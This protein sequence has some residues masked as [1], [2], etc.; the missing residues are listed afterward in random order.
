MNTSLSIYTAYFLVSLGM[1]IQP[2]W[3]ELVCRSSTLVQHPLPE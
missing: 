2:L 1:T 3:I